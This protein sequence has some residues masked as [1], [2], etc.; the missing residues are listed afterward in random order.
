MYK[1]KFLKLR[2]PVDGDDGGNPPDNQSEEMKALNKSLEDLKKEVEDLKGQNKTLKSELDT[3]KKDLEETKKS[4]ADT[5]E[6]Y[7]DMFGEKGDKEPK[8][9]KDKTPQ[10]DLFDYISECELK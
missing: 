10:K 6:A 9:D 2:Y 4:L 1:I 3:S 7:K 5:K 8:K